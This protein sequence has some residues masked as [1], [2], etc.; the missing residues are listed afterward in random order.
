MAEDRLLGPYWGS[1]SDLEN[2][3]RVEFGEPF[4]VWVLSQG[5]LGE[6]RGYRQ[7]WGQGGLN[8]RTEGEHRREVFVWARRIRVR[9]WG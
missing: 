1:N 5:C 8:Q 2:L 7:D 9:C 6:E 4:W 3:F